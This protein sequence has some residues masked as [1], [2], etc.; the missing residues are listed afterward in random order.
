ME[1][2]KK[3]GTVTKK[4]WK[5]GRNTEQCQKKC[6][7]WK[8]YGTVPKKNGKCRRYMLPC[9]KKKSE[10][11]GITPEMWNSHILTSPRKVTFYFV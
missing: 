7:C 11:P 2:W 1:G 6:E 3:Y 10:C 5:G 4:K 8:K 9:I